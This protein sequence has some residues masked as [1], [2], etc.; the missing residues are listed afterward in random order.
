M[1][2][3]SEP[4]TSTAT[5]SEMDQGMSE[6][7]ESVSV[8]EMPNPTATESQSAWMTEWHL[9]TSMA[10][11]LDLATSTGSEMDRVMSKVRES[12]S[13]TERPMADQT[14]AVSAS[15]PASAGRPHSLSRSQGSPHESSAQVR[16]IRS[17]PGSRRAWHSDSRSPG[18]KTFRRSSNIPHDHCDPRQA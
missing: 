15:G 1:A 6:V 5:G 2:S 11:D 8:T 12:V 3:D 7:R 18:S 10:S 14:E 16:S 9:A 4:T 13:V 17:V